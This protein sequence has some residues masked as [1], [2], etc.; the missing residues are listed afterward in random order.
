MLSVIML[1]DVMLSVVIMNAI[2]LSVHMPLC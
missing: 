2:I 1:R